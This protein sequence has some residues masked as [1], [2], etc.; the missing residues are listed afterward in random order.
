LYRGILL[1]LLALFRLA[2]LRLLLLDGITL[3]LRIND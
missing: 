2:L 3:H 1:L